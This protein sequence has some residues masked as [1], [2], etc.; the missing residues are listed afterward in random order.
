M[1]H[2]KMFLA[3]TFPALALAPGD[4]LL[5]W[6]AHIKETFPSVNH[7]SCE[8]LHAMIDAASEPPPLLLD[9]RAAH[10][11]ACSHIS[12]SVRVDP[13]A[14]PGDIVKLLQQHG[15]CMSQ[16]HVAVAPPPAPPQMKTGEG[17]EGGGRAAVFYCS[18]GAAARA[19]IDNGRCVCLR[20][21]YRG[22]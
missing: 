17:G 3:Q 20:H 13:D 16:H 14:T 2:A 4:L 9:F 8:Q 7:I 18:I 10:E 6:R 1:L 12:G 22:V 5:E 21:V 15:V 19:A 11:H